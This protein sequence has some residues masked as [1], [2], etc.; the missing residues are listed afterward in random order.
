MVA[1]LHYA[2]HFLPMLKD[3]LENVDNCYKRGL[4]RLHKFQ[5]EM[6]EGYPSFSLWGTREKR[7]G[8]EKRKAKTSSKS[9]EKLEF[10]LLY[11]VSISGLV[12]LPL[13]MKGLSIIALWRPQFCHVAGAITSLIDR[14]PF[15]P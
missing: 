14:C 4:S 15:M 13:E 8:R 9:H 10:K 2:S 7:M 5:A 12:I 3:S 11:A 1:V 6:G